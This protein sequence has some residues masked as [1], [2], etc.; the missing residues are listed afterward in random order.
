MVGL[1]RRDDDPGDIKS[2]Y[3]PYAFIVLGVLVSLAIVLLFSYQLV[4]RRRQDAIF[5]REL[6][7]LADPEAQAQA[8]RPSRSRRSR[9]KIPRELLD[10]IPQ[11][12]YYPELAFP[13]KAASTAESATSEVEMATIIPSSGDNETRTSF[14]EEP[15]KEGL[16]N[17]PNSRPSL[18]LKRPEVAASKTATTTTAAT[19]PQADEDR[20]E[21]QRQALISAQTACVICLDDFIPGSSII[22]ELPCHHIFHA[23]CIDTFL[24]RSSSLCPLCKRDLLVLIHENAKSSCE[25]SCTD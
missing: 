7:R 8:R 13:P 20:L 15:N 23:K 22:R 10:N 3:W 18:E 17:E 25:Q 12:T 6:A 5:R 24:T 1:Q 11:Y 14:R 21:L 19:S 4:Q 9:P 16:N 2:R